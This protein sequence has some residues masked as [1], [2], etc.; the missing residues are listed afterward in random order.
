MNENNVM[1]Y[2]KCYHENNVVGYIKSEGKPFPLHGQ[3]SHSAVQ[4]A[5][6]SHCS[7]FA[8]AGPAL[9]G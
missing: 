4:D 1:G 5:R 2:I 9:A 6:H 3:L 8:K 7:S